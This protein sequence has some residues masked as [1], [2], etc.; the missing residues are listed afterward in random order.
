MV[1]ALRCA[2]TAVFQSLLRR[3]RTPRSYSLSAL[4]VAVGWRTGS[5]AGLL[6][7]A[8]AAAG[9][10]A[11]AAITALRT[12]RRRAVRLERDLSMPL[13]YRGRSRVRSPG[14]AGA[15]GHQRGDRLQIG[16]GVDADRRLRGLDDHDVDPVLEEPQLL[17]LLRELERRLREPMEGLERRLA[18][19]IEALMLE[20]HYADPVPIVGDRVLREIE[21]APVHAAD[22]LVHIRVRGLLRRQADLQRA[23]LRGGSVAERAHQEPD[24]LGR[25]QGLVALHVHVHVRGAALRDLPDPIGP[26]RMLRRGQHRRDAELRA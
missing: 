9:S 17:E 23:H 8:S 14:R 5:P 10:S 26:R 1:T 25:E 2:S 21:R 4:G 12:M 19:R 11:E 13:A 20:A 6:G 3:A 18:I 15:L 22:D 16:F 24:V 7:S